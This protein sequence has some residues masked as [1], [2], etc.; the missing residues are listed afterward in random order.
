MP[1][2]RFRFAVVLASLVAAASCGRPPDKEIEEARSAIA[3]AQAEGAAEYAP[4]EL[5]AARDA[6]ERASQAVTER[7]YQLALNHALDSRERAQNAERQAVEAGAAAR[8]AADAAIAAASD[9][10]AKADTL[11]ADAARA[12]IAALRQAPVREAAADVERAVQEARAA[13]GR[14]EWKAATA[15]VEAPT[16]RLAAAMRDLES[17][18]AAAPGARRR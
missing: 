12:R 8:A 18:V 4:E 7:D 2:G 14:S 10:R 16:A 6:L 9:A 13:A 15:A 1:S 3:S 5:A 11:L 17:A